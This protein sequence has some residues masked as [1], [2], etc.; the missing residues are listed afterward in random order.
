MF[1]FYILQNRRV[2]GFEAHDQKAA[3]RLP[4]GFEGFE[5]GG[6]PGIAGPGHPEGLQFPAEIQDAR[7]SNG[8]RVVVKEY[9]LDPGEQLLRSPNF[10]QHIVAAARAPMV[11]PHGL[12]PETKCA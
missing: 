10:G 4:H 1:L 7:F 3:S 8:K 12:R 2:S 5:I 11:A 6:H 9:L